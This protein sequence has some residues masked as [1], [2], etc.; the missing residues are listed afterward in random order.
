MSHPTSEPSEP[1]VS[2]HAVRDQRINP[3][4]R[5]GTVVSGDGVA[6]SWKGII[7]TGGVLAVLALFWGFFRIVS[8]VQDTPGKV[9]I[10]IATQKTQTDTLNSFGAQLRNI[11]RDLVS[12]Q[13]KETTLEVR[14]QELDTWRAGIDQL[15]ESRAR[16]LADLQTRLRDI[17]THPSRRD[18]R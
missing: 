15:K 13:A 7:Q 1:S 5:R 18:P 6:A 16:D 11:T 9:D 12:V 2:V 14:V 4:R 8:T 10:V 17:E 3:D